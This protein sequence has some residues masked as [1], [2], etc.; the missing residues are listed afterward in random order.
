GMRSVNVDLIYCLPR[1]TPAGFATTLDTVIGARPDRIAVYGYAHLPQLF[2]AQ[3]KIEATEPPS[4]EAKLALLA[5][6]IEKLTGAGYVYIGMDHFALP[7]DEL[8]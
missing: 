5:L 3:R 2:K 6:A 8:A 4:A 1:Q 7:R